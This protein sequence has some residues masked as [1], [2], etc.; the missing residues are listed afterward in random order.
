MGDPKL[1]LILI[2]LGSL[3]F[4]AAASCSTSLE[5][6]RSKALFVED[7]SRSGVA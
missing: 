2:L 4:F 7:I 6:P 5:P 3:V 1:I